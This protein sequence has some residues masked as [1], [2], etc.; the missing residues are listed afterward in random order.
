MPITSVGGGDAQ[1]GC[2]GGCVDV[3]EV[4]AEFKEERAEILVEAIEVEVVDERRR[5]HQP[6]IGFSGGVIAALGAPHERLLLRAAHEQYPLGAGEPGQELL[7]HL[8]FAFLAKRHQL[9]P[10]RGDEAVDV[11][12]E[13]LGHD[14]ALSP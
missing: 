11:G 7:G 3:G 2:G 14:P 5:A 9:Q 4:G 10:A 13:R 8:V 12:D 6:G 1:R